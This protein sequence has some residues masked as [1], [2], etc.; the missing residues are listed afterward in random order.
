LAFPEK[1]RPKTAVAILAEQ[2]A[3]KSAPTLKTISFAQL[4][5]WSFLD[6]SDRKKGKPKSQG[7]K[8]YISTKFAL[9]A[10]SLVTAMLLD[11]QIEHQVDED[12]TPKL[13]A[14]ISKTGGFVAL[15]SG[16][17][18]K[19]ILRKIRKAN[20]QARY[21]SEIVGYL[22]RCQ[23]Q[24]GGKPATIDNAKKFV[25]NRQSEL[26]LIPIKKR[27][28]AKIWETF[29]PAAPYI[30]ALY[31]E[32]KFKTALGRDPVAVLRWLKTFAGRPTRIDRFLGRAASAHDILKTSSHRQRT[33]DFENVKR[34]ILTGHPFDKAERAIH[35]AIL[36]EDPNAAIDE[37]SYRAKVL[38][39]KRSAQS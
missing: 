1:F 29:A 26:G 13:L 35:Q 10:L 31:Q 30:F 36:D 3:E 5:A 34:Q 16:S 14:I 24:P 6:Q 28:V 4:I 33:S 32:P 39:F 18:A 27:T 21:V 25:T 7:K 22:V 19:S 38:P 37:P 9:R 20:E 17:S 11:D 8:H 12:V 15:A 23:A 2:S